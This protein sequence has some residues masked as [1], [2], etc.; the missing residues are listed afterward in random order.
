MNRKVIHLSILAAGVFGFAS[1]AFAAHNKHPVK[2]FKLDE[3]NPGQLAQ[4]KYPASKAL[5]QVKKLL[6]NGKIV[7]GGIE[8]EK[9]Q[10]MYSFDVRTPG[11]SGIDEVN[12][13]ALDGK[14]LAKTHEGK[15]DEVKEAKD[16][17]QDAK[18]EEADEHGKESVDDE[19]AVKSSKEQNDR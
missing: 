19:P 9:G 15:K 2:A 10:L 12:I 3:D 13:S 1:H 5:A 4:A 8:E 14:L 6:P 17:V 16:E 7:E 11:K 18:K